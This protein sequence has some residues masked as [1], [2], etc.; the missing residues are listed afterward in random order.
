MTGRRGLP[1]LAAVA[2]IVTIIAIPLWGLLT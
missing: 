2:L 1:G